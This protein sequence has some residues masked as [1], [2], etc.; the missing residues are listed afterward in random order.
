MK[1][2]MV[3]PTPTHP[4]TAGNRARVRSLVRALQE[5]GH[6]VH[7]AL[8]ST[9][10]PDLDAMRALLGDRLHLLD[11]RKPDAVDGFVPK[12]K[13]LLLRTVGSEAAY[14][15]GLDDFYD[16]RL[17]P[18]V[19]ALCARHAFDAAFVEYV[20]MSKA[21]D[22]MP[23]GILKILDTHDHFALRHR[24]FLDA[25][26]TPQW[27]STSVA[28][29]NAGFRR[30]DFILAIQEREADVFA[31]QLGEAERVVAVGH[32]LD[33]QERIVPATAPSAVFFGS[34]NPINVD[35]A[36][37]FIGSVLPLVLRARPDFKFILAGDVG[38]SFVTAG[39]AVVRMGRVATI[40]D[41]FRAAAVA[42]NPVR[43]GTG[44]SIKMLEALACGAACI[45]SATGSRGLERHRGSAFE[46]VWDN[47]A[48]SMAKVVLHLLDNPARAAQL[49]NAGFALAADWNRQQ[50]AG[51]TKVLS[52]VRA[53]Q[54]YASSA[55]CQSADS[56]ALACAHSSASASE[57]AR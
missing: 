48:D 10:Q 26:L 3:S 56:A 42:V 57:V 45:S 31:R 2:L 41:A 9:A 46:H 32:L 34:S 40:G 33:V 17:T 54:R 24:T 12:L 5:L 22:A 21:F 52:P 7:F 47:D 16:P 14:T 15:W 13:R 4:T 43:V 11:T 39:S 29:E 30:A 18:Q 20:Y 35:A 6:E 44:L 25:G 38:D 36:Q 23:P 49:S 27:F 51:L 55:A 53:A 28:E 8:A 50:L 1:I 19:A 37:Y